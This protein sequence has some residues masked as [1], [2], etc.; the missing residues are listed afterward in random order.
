MSIAIRAAVTHS[1]NGDVAIE[2]LTLDSPG[3]GEV[4]VR[5]QASGICHTDF[6][7]PKVMPLPAVLGH[8]GT[9]EVVEVGEGVSGIRQGDRVVGSYGC[10]GRCDNCVAGETFH[11]QDFSTIQLGSRRADSAALHRADGTPVSGAFFEQSSFA[12]HALMTE[13]NCV[14]VDTRLPAEYLAPLGCGVIT[15]FGA[16]KAALK[17]Q[18]GQSLLVIGAG[19]VGL[20]AVMA[21]RIAGC[22]PIIA[23]DLL[24]ARLEQARAF[25]ATHLLRGDEPNLLESI[26]AL[27]PGGVD[28]GLETVAGAATFNLGLQATRAGG[29][30]GVVALPNM[31]GAFEISSGR[32]LLKL[33]IVGIIEG[34]CRPQDTIPELVALIEQGELPMSEYVSVFDFDDIAAA[35]AAGR[36]GNVAKPVLRMPALSGA[37]LVF[38]CR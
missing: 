4:L 25:G 23:I 13:R 37:V 2:E 8:E 1:S 30:F 33:D 19:G 35:L 29:R 38:P 14:R 32:P 5:V 7:A 21:A 20:S 6:L 10:C 28:F 3:P 11:C 12:T 31:G 18:A 26:H 36:S 34:R 16:V 27:C 17:P 22:D 15:G 9:G 24:P